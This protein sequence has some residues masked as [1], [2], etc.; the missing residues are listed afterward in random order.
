MAASGDGEL[1]GDGREDDLNLISEPDQDGNRDNRDESQDQRV[2]DQGL[3]FL[4][5]PFAVEC[6][7]TAHAI[8][9]SI[10][11]RLSTLGVG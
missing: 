3:A 11:E 5:L 9:L 10:P 1:A 6:S 7:E 4:E 8:I 2:L